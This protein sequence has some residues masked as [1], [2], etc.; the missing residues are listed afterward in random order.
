[1]FTMIKKYS[2]KRKSRKLLLEILKNDHK[3]IMI[4]SFT[5]NC[6]NEVVRV[7]SSIGNVQF[8]YNNTSIEHDDHFTHVYIRNNTPF[9]KEMANSDLVLA[10][11]GMSAFKIVKSR[12]GKVGT[13][14]HV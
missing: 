12:Y 11:S 4:Y 9:H 1:M 10:Q 14:I 6:E 8:H 5:K 13:L 2:N 7:I 3:S